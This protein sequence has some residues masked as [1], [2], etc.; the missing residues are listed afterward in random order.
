[1]HDWPASEQLP[2][3]DVETAIPRLA[4]GTTASDVIPVRLDDGRVL[5]GLYCPGA[6]GD[7][8]VE[9]PFAPREWTLVREGRVVSWLDVESCL[10]TAPPG[11]S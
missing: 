8:A 7:W 3:I 6:E 1:M 4:T 2:W 9:F 10:T 5:R 11:G